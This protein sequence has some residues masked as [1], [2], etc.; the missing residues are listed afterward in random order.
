MG[1]E[2]VLYLRFANSMLEPVWNRHHAT[3]L[4]VTQTELRLVFKHPPPLGFL[5]GSHRRPQL[6]QVVVKVDPS[7]GVRIVL[8]VLRPDRSG[9]MKIAL[10]ADLAAD[11]AEGPVPYEVLLHAA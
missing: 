3:S 1:L 10:D 2:D 8:D 6:S 11:G 7:T 5:A 4:P 9:P